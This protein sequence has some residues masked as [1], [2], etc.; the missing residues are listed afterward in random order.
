MKT[1]V[2]LTDPPVLA[3]SGVAPMT[4]ADVSVWYEWLVCSGTL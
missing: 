2:F 1:R 4:G 3:A